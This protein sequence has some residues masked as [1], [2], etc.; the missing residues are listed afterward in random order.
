MADLLDVD[1]L[2]LLLII[3]LPGFISI[4]IWGLINPTAVLKTADYLIDAICYSFFNFA[5]LFWLI[6]IANGLD[7]KTISALLFILILIVFPAVWPILLKIFLSAKWLRGKTLSPIPKAWDYFFGKCESCFMLLHLKNGKKIGGLYHRDSFASAYPE[8]RD[9]YI[10][11]LWSTDERGHFLS[12]IPGTKGM[13][14]S[15]DVVDYIELFRI[16]GED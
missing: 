16:D 5:G 9:L 4:K 8:S 11:E 7:N 10:S 13:L 6:P 1:K 3:V 14:I 15:H 12:K 2:Q